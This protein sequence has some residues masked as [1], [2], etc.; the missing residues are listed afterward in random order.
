[1]GKKV[2][3]SKAIQEAEVALESARQELEETRSRL[4]QEKQ[5]TGALVRSWV[6]A[7]AAARPGI[8]GEQGRNQ[9]AIVN[10][11]ALCES[12]AGELQARE[13][14]LRDAQRD[15][16]IG[17][18]LENLAAC[19]AAADRIRLATR[20]VL[21][22]HVSYI[23]AK[24]QFEGAR[25]ALRRV[26]PKGNL[27]VLEGSEAAVAI[28]RGPKLAPQ[29]RSDLAVYDHAGKT[30]Q[31]LTASGALDSDESGLGLWIRQKAARLG[32]GPNPPS[33]GKTRV[34]RAGTKW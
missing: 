22:A 6:K 4:E 30:L 23:D 28:Q 18:C 24:Q 19:S 27:E 13:G 8:E 11:A 9:F 1:M 15:A 14:E 26:C 5:R 33:F 7:D 21:E 16:Q 20:E 10:L 3:A 29:L 34:F 12:L 2:E 31:A 17:V 25:N 32:I